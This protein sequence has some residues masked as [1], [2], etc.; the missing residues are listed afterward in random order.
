MRVIGEHLKGIEGRI[1]DKETVEAMR[2][3]RKETRVTREEA[4]ERAR[5]ERQES[6][7]QMRINM[8][9]RAVYDT[10]LLQVRVQEY[11]HPL[12]VMSG[13]AEVYGNFSSKNEDLQRF[14]T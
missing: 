13:E 10:R 12:A 8:G 7:T 5:K 4:G 1:R 2:E 9:L 11:T 14:D 6:E 3:E